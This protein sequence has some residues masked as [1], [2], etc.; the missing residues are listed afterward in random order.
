MAALDKGL[1][2]VTANKGPLVLYYKEI[3]DLAKTKGCRI[4]M[5]AATAAALP[6]LDVGRL[7]LA[8][9]VR[10]IDQCRS[11]RHYQVDVRARQWLARC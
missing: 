2:I 1:N 10:H 3:L 9:D 11:A 8:G 4:S 5:S 7:C 6:A